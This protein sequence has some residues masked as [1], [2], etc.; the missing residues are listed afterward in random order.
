VV[1]LSS[2]LGLGGK[3]KDHVITKLIRSFELSRNCSKIKVPSVVER[4]GELGNIG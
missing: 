3:T 2:E 1:Q 4:T